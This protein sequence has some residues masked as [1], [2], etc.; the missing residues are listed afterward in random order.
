MVL[1]RFDRV[2][3]F[4]FLHRID[5]DL[6]ARTKSERCPY[7]GGPLHSAH[8]LRK[9][10]GESTRLPEDMFKRLGLCCGNRKCR[11]RTLP[12]SVLFMGRR[13]YWGWVVVLVTALGQGLRPGYSYRRLHDQFGMSLSTLKRWRQWFSGVRRTDDWLRLSGLMRVDTLDGAQPRAL[14]EFLFSQVPDEALGMGKYLLLLSGCP[15]GVVQAV[16][17]MAD[18]MHAEDGV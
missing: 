6:G 9:P 5:V 15:P 18:E 2:S 14:L 4:S 7:C 11:R 17:V 13:V 10:R 3:F 16:L 1:H 8:Y 12:P